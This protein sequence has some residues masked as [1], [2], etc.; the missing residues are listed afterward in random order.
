MKDIILSHLKTIE[1]EERVRIVYACESGSRAWGFPSSD[2]DFDVRFIY[3]HSLD[4]YLSIEK[5]REVIECPIEGNLDINGWDLRKALQLFRKSNPPLLEWLGSPI[6]YREV[7]SVAT[8]LR[9]LAES[10]YSPTASLHHYLHMAQGNYREY[11]QGPNVWVK[12]YFYVLRPT[13]AMLWIEQEKGVVPTDF[14]ILVDAV[15]TEHE[16]KTAIHDLLVYKRAGAEL[17]RGPRIPVISNFIDRELTRLE[18]T[19]FTITK[20]PFSIEMLNQIFRI[21]LAESWETSNIP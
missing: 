6:V 11:L 2:S 16:L 8:R 15:V 14:H 17:D 1:T 13:L 7:G 3:I 10:A 9:T 20:S 4:W 21:G 18:K 5:R 12:K 19:K